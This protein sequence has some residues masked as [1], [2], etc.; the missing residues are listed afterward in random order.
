MRIVVIR[1]GAL[2]D[3]L[4]CLPVLHALRA[5][6]AYTHLTLVGNAA[7]L[8]LA[9]AW[10]IAE[11]VY[12]YE[13]MLWSDLF[14]TRGIRAPRLLERLQAA[15]LVI[16]WL[17]DPDG[18]VESNLRALRIKQ[19]IVAPGRPL[20]GS[21]LHL[22]AY[23]AQTLS[24]PNAIEITRSPVTITR[25]P[26]HKDAPFAIHPGSGG[27]AKCWP[28][29]AFAEL[30]TRFWQHGQAILLLAGPAERDLLTRLLNLLPTPSRAELLTILQDVPLNALAARLQG[31]QG[32]LGNDAG[33]THLAA[34]LGLP[35][36]SLFGPSDPIIWR[37]VGPAVSVLHAPD[38]SALSVDHVW[39][40]LE[41][42]LRA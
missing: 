9:Q 3:T 21:S 22:T 29:P 36:L 35:T 33:I 15:D 41:A 5:R 11:S 26:I 17:R 10:G 42:M 31:C 6:Y 32:Y 39:R 19:V 16:G 14:S 1:P 37:P 38:L 4:L 25:P 13:E 23:L 18:R 27:V 40:A 34:L 2:G 28:V 24:L 20:P 8:P 7:V 30:I 12:D